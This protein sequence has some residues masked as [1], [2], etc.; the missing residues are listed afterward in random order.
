M[1]R[2]TKV[3]T[4]NVGIQFNERIHPVGRLAYKDYKIY[5]EY[6]PSFLTKDL[7]LSPFKLNLQAGL[8]Q[9][10]PSPFEGLAGLFNDSLPD[11][12][13]RLLLDRYM[14]SNNILSG[15]LSPLDRLAHVGS[16]GLGALVYSPDYGSQSTVNSAIKLDKL[17][18]ETKLILSG[19]SSAIIK[20]LLDLN[21][22]SAGARPK[23][24]IGVSKDKKQIISGKNQ[25]N[26]EYEAWMVKFAN[27]TDGQQA[28]AIEYVYALLAKKAGI[29]M[30]PVHLFPSEEHTGYFATKRFDRDGKQR[31]HMHTA[32]GL[33]HHDFRIPSLDYEDLCNLTGAL[34][35]DYREVEKMFRYAVFNVFAH[36]RDDHSKNV[37]FLM[38]AQGEW[39]LAP[40]YDVTFSSGPGGEQSMLV[41]GEGAQ[42]KEKH[43]RKLAQEVGIKKETSTE[44]IEECKEALTHWKTLAKEHGISTN[45]STLIQKRMNEILK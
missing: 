9:F 30:M 18:E 38:N 7:H 13:G 16:N 42:P 34:T 1:S 17:S 36:N 12:W 27:S 26:K 31:L 2:Y 20:E 8:Q 10:N 35:K 5:F 6:D 39:H 45:N 24:L 14:R 37:S 22:S 21:G 41:M 32:S 44:I 40:A 29:E 4:L 23:A 3:T 11:G 25:L 19:E 15:E 28:G 43:L 33:L